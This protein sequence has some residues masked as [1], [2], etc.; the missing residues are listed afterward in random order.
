MEVLNLLSESVI[1]ETMKKQ[2]DAFLEFVSV[3]SEK[4]KSNF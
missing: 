2:Q 3:V 4:S 1:I